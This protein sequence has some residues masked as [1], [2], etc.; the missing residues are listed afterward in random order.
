[1]VIRCEKY[2]QKFENKKF[3]KPLRVFIFGG[4][5][6]SRAINN[7]LF[8]LYKDVEVRTWE[9][10]FVHQIGALDYSKFSEL[11]KQL[12][13]E[14]KSKIQIHE[15][16]QDMPKYYNWAHFAICRAGMG[17]VAEL[18]AMGVPALFVP[19]PNS[20]DD[21]QLKNAESLVQRKAAALI[22]QSDLNLES[23]KSLI[24]KYLENPEDLSLMSQNM[25]SF[26]KGEASRKIVISIL[27]EVGIDT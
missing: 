26:H 24:K 5:Q 18:S 16:I 7:I 17:T 19:L 9:I 12:P 27:K 11:Y 4:S 21:H 15:F 8:E 20:A 6:G 25:H 10:E 3:S 22:R 2:F 13:E 1:M 23:L 14:I